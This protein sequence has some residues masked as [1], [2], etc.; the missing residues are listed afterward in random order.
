MLRGTS[1]TTHH[2]TSLPSHPCSTSPLPRHLSGATHTTRPCPSPRR[3][4]PAVPFTPPPP[5]PPAAGK[6]FLALAGHFATRSIPASRT[7]AGFSNFSS[8]ASLAG[9]RP[10]TSS[11]SS[12]PSL[13]SPSTSTSPS[14]SSSFYSPT[15]DEARFDPPALPGQYAP[16]FR[17]MSAPD[18]LAF[19]T[20]DPHLPAS[21]LVE[22]LSSLLAEKHRAELP[23]PMLNP[24]VRDLALRAIAAADDMDLIAL[25]DLVYCIY[26]L[27]WC[28]YS[29]TSAYR[30]K[31]LRPI[32]TPLRA[33]VSELALL[34]QQDPNNGQDALSLSGEDWVHLLT[35]LH[36]L[37]AEDKL[38][39]E[40]IVRLC[41]PL[42]L[43]MSMKHVA[44]LSE[45]LAHFGL[46]NESLL[47]A[48][49]EVARNNLNALQTMPGMHIR[50]LASLARMQY[51]HPVVDEVIS[52]LLSQH[53][54]WSGPELVHAIRAMTI[55]S[56]D[57]A[58]RSRA[59]S[60][61]VSLLTP[62]RLQ[63]LSLQ[64]L[65]ILL[66]KLH[67]AERTQLVGPLAPETLVSVVECV[68]TQAQRAVRGEGHIEPRSLGALWHVL[69]EYKAAQSTPVLSALTALTLNT[70]PKLRADPL[71]GLISDLVASHAA[72]RFR[73]LE[74][75]EDKLELSRILS[76][77]LPPEPEDLM[78]SEEQQQHLKAAKTRYEQYKIILE[79]SKPAREERARILQVD[80][81]IREALLQ[82]TPQEVL[83]EHFD[84]GHYLYALL[85]R[86]LSLLPP[87]APYL[88]HKQ[89]LPKLCDT[90]H[91]AHDYNI[92][93]LDLQKPLARA[94]IDELDNVSRTFTDL[95]SITAY[96]QFF[97]VEDTDEADCDRRDR[98]RDALVGNLPQA[99]TGACVEKQSRALACLECVAQLSP[100]GKLSQ[101]GESV[102]MYLLTSTP[103]LRSRK[104]LELLSIIGTHKL[105][106][107]A[108]IQTVLPQLLAAATRAETTSRLTHYGMKKM[109]ELLPMY[110]LA[111]NE[112]FLQQLRERCQRH[113]ALKALG[114]MLEKTI[115]QQKKAT[116]ASGKPKTQPAAKR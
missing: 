43:S 115:Q 93:P 106:Q 99:I 51:Q 73:G 72:D 116:T 37:G 71:V 66:Q 23:E 61:F 110:D 8:I 28:S 69:G 87:L 62:A 68:T 104:L 75:W 2:F 35:D 102:L 94:V 70:M 34:S 78:M 96:L 74:R 15:P 30:E 95:A 56:R 42:V 101:E 3:R 97:A 50:F 89:V 90:V 91:R 36:E 13:S 40:E 48:L 38:L 100:P 105:Q 1:K 55:N 84:P 24:A 54:L 41:F 92:L 103:P 111:K 63:E 47:Q 112:Q 12:S 59:L 5:A 31:T 76:E 114:K 49:C 33:R 45:A 46:P 82:P 26:K 57:K 107:H 29:D 80:Q 65:S 9:S 21:A 52:A 18:I 83:L 85:H 79:H 16:S 39:V 7:A 113:P 22:A 108:R 67:V 19:L 44:G 25:K 27:R 10:F 88:D 86:A 17:H 11:P 4:F 98:V 77:T 81:Q 58:E 20:L 64:D 14:P 109:I 32:L 60:H 53:V 6:K